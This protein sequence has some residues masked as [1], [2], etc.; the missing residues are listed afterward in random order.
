MGAHRMTYTA[1]HRTASDTQVG[2]RTESQLVRALVGGLRVESGPFGPLALS[3]EFFYQR[4]RTD[5][6]GVCAK[7]SVFAFEAKLTKWRAA[8]QQAY[9]NTCFAHVSYVVLPWRT[10]KLA[11]RFS[12]EFDRRRVGI[13]TVQAGSV[14]VLHEARLSDPIEP[15]LSELATAKARRRG[16]HRAAVA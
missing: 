16:R 5:L 6:V 12:A 3:R 7:G 10:A 4:G 11:Q 1:Q 8:L 2:Y 15:W 13:C 14:V 9:R